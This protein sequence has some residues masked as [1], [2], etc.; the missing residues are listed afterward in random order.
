MHRFVYQSKDEAGTARFGRALAQALPETAT[1]ALIGTLGAGKTRLVQ[2]IA[3][4]CGI[5][6]GS[7]TSPTFVLCQPYY[8]TRTLY[9][10]DAYRTRSLEEFL[11]LGVDEYFAGPGITLIEW[12]ERVAAC[13]PED[14]L[15]IQIDI[16]GP[17]ERT[18][19]LVAHGPHAAA[20]LARLAEQKIEKR[21]ESTSS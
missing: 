14:Y 10:L 19:A 15:E 2:A 11:E 4:G 6:P 12:A 7:V 9:H 1:L 8:G 16:T 18:F 20:T 21:D 17:A 13:L 3:E 5:E